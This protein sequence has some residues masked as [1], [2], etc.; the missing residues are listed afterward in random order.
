[1][2][3]PV[4]ST[5]NNSKKMFKEALKYVTKILTYFVVA[6]VV[7]VGAFLIYYV[8]S[9]AL[10]KNS[11]K[12]IP[13]ITLYTI[14]SPSM[15]PVI[16]VFDVII[17]SRIDDVSLIEVGDV[18]TFISTSSM[19]KDMR[20]THRVL[21]IG[22]EDG[23]LVFTTKGDN[24]PTADSDT[25]KA[26]NVIGKTIMKIPQIGRIQRLLSTKFGWLVVVLI[27]ALG[28]I[29]FD[30][31]KL[32][33]ILSVKDEAEQIT[34]SDTSYDEITKYEE[35]KKINE[36]LEK[37]M[38]KQPQI[39]E[40]I[41]EPIKEKSDNIA[42]VGGE[43]KENDFSLPEENLLKEDK[44]EKST[45]KEDDSKEILVE[46]QIE[47][48]T[49]SGI[50]PIESE[51]PSEALII[52]EKHSE[53]KTTDEIISKSEIPSEFALSEEVRAALLQRDEPEEGISPPE[54]EELSVEGR[55]DDY[56]DQLI[57]DSAAKNLENTR[58]NEDITDTIPKEVEDIIEPSKDDF[59]DNIKK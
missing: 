51:V 20:V 27:P 35:D 10:L 24:N 23:R 41:I 32:F 43:I 45:K 38:K 29:I 58:Q 48:K 40:D 34:D 25:A 49:D 30:I 5:E 55:T 50:L 52:E 18:I 56:I 53:E 15:E 47:E 33:K 36:T 16:K 22:E 44:D 3:K 8:I 7:I 42:I 39:K 9:S 31:F 11:E 14:V 6:I 37:I 4:D 12:S 19:S 46:E 2:N 26:E 1:M 59:D 17:V 54:K 13:K 28:V 21:D 57:K